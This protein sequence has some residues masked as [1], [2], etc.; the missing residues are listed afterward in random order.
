MNN[1]ATSCDD[2]VKYRMDILYGRCEIDSWF[3]PV[4]DKLVGMCSK[5]TIDKNGKVIAYEE[6]ET[7]LTLI[8]D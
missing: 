7:G 1:I 2:S 5:T 3:M 8:A 4:G 6:S